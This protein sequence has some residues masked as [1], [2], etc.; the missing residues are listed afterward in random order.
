MNWNTIGW[1]GESYL[2]IWLISEKARILQGKDR[3]SYYPSISTI[4]PT[5]NSGRVLQECLESLF[6]QEYP[7]EALEVLLVDGGSAF[8]G[9]E[10]RFD[11]TEDGPWTSR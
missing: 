7:K 1:R 3:M 5:L 11:G 6:M 8:G 2:P 4:I 10:I 9:G